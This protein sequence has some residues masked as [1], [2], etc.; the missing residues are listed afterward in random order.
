[1]NFTTWDFVKMGISSI[2]GFYGYYVLRVGKK[3]MNTNKMLLGG[4][5]LIASTW[6]FW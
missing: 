5:L 1:M 2:I 4:A 3:E 6:M